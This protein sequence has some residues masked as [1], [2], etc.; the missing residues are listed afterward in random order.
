MI[1]ILGDP[2]KE[3][4]RVKVAWERYSTLLDQTNNPTDPDLVQS[5]ALQSAG[6]AQAFVE[7]VWP[8]VKA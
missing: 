1:T 6:Y 4:W 3:E 2:K 8:N 5:L 7:A